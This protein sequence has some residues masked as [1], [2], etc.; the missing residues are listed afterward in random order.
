MAKPN[1]N[2]TMK[3]SHAVPHGRSLIERIEAQMDKRRK[4]MRDLIVEHGSSVRESSQY[5]L[6]KGRYEGM[7]GSLAILRSSSMQH[8]LERSNE[9][10]G[11]S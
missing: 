7:A 1:L 2:K 9:R 10:L 3:N 6:Q 4:A 5:A 8:E 11:I